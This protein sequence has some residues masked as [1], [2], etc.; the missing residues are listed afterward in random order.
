VL[1]DP[2]ALGSHVAGLK[3]FLKKTL[4]LSGKLL[5]NVITQ[6]YTANKEPS[7]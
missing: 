6:R 3:D 4:R 5:M 7:R 1:M 2:H